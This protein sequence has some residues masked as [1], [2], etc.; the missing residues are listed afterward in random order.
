MQNESYNITFPFPFPFPTQSDY[1]LPHPHPSR[2][3]NETRPISPNHANLTQLNI[4]ALSN[5]G[6]SILSTV[7]LC[8]QFVALS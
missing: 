7:S 5:I 3:T 8:K 2:L 6:V 4:T 1:T